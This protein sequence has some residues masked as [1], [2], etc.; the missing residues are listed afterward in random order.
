MNLDSIKAKIGLNTLYQV[1]GRLI[2]AA[3]GLIVTRLVIHQLGATGFG[4]FQ[5]AVSYVT[6]FWMLTDFGLNAVVVRK[7]SAEP[8]KEEKYFNG[9]ITLRVA[10]SLALMAISALVLIFLPY[11]APVKIAALLGMLT[12]LTQGIKGSTHGLFQTRLRYD[13]QLISYVLGSAGYLGAIYWVLN[14]TQGIVGL[15]AAFTLGQI[16]SALVDIYFARRLS[17]LHLSRDLAFLKSLFIATLPF[18]ISLLFNLGNFKLDAFLLSVLDLP[19]HSNA[20]AVGI[21]NVGYKFF[22]FGLVFPTFFMNAVYPV[23]VKRFE[24]SLASFKKLFWQSAGVLLVTALVGTTLIFL[25]APWAVSL[26][27]DLDEFADS[28]TV[29]RILIAQAPIFFL[30][31]LLMWAVLTFEDQRTLIKVYASAFVVNLV[32]NLIFIPQFSYFAAAVTTGISELVI[33][34]LLIIQLKPKW[35]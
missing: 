21:Y 2:T 12:I 1:A 27:A 31:S 18:G 20:D 17:R 10:L 32:L 4:E 6:I 22:E 11:S 14:S 34:T 23:M 7:M 5:I 29:L 19:H 24:E 15:V 16:I 33:L 13:L 9:L 8:E 25:L 30:S 3:T 35:N 26:V 28:V